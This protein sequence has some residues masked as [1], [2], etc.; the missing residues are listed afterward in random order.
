MPA[1]NALTSRIPTIDSARP[2]PLILGLL[3]VLASY[4]GPPE[5]NRRR[6]A[7]RH[8][9]AWSFSHRF[10][11]RI[12]QMPPTKRNKSGEV[13]IIDSTNFKIATSIAAAI[14]T[15]KPGGVRELH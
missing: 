4:S 1:A 8:R 9:K 11:F 2:V 6:F 7:P 5:M 14:V 10:A 3:P 13:R 15:V 12:K